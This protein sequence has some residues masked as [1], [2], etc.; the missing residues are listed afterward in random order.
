MGF[1]FYTIKAERS[2]HMDSYD[3]EPYLLDD[4]LFPIEE[5]EEDDG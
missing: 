2:G 5:R 4:D 3:N 1:F